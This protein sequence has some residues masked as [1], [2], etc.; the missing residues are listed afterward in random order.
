MKLPTSLKLTG[1][2][3][4]ALVVSSSL[5]AEIELTKEFAINGYV[6]GSASASKLQGESSD[7]N[8][9]LDAYKLQGIAKFDKVSITGSAFAFG[10]G[11]GDGFGGSP[12]ILDAY[13]TYDFGGGTTVTAGKFLSWL[14]YEAFD[15]IN[16][17]QLSYANTGSTGF[18]PAY[19][20]GVKAETSNEQFSAGIA[21]LDSIYGPTYYRGDGDLNDGIGLEAYVTY[22]AI[23]DFTL[24][25]GVSYDTGDADKTKALTFDV[26]AQYVYGKVTF[27]GEFCYGNKDYAGSAS[28]NGYFALGLVKYAF[29]EK[30]SLTGRISTGEGVDDDKFTRFTI[31][32]AYS[33][34]KNL[35][36]VAEYSYTDL[37]NTGAD[38]AH[39]AGLQA[40]FKF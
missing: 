19:H 29:D 37:S 23:K 11:S 6:V 2:A 25:A 14:G 20:T 36:L 3:A 33:V 22:K 27:A 9:D 5:M 15:P 31:A 13:G 17:L 7:S 8:M 30:W 16:M 4:A 34:T 39:Y 12:I 10:T 35:D 26:W 38:Y 32:P 18:I 24:F 28:G 40:R 1:A 21:V